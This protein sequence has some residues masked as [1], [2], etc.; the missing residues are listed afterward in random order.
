MDFV[1]AEPRSHHHH[2]RPTSFLG[3]Q[4]S[5]SQANLGHLMTIQWSPASGAQTDSLAA[6]LNKLF[7]NTSTFFGHLPTT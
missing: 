1:N 2:N 3:L 4:F 7:V 6:E 5:R